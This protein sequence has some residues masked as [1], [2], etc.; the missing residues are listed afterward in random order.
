M[1]PGCS[2]KF[3]GFFGARRHHCR[4]CG[5]LVCDEHS[6]SRLP[7][8]DIYPVQQEGVMQGTVMPSQ[9][10]VL[11]RVCDTCARD[12]AVRKRTM[13]GVCAMCG[14]KRVVPVAKPPAPAPQLQQHP[15]SSAAAAAAAATATAAAAAAAAA[16][17]ASSV[18]AAVTLPASAEAKAADSIDSA[19]TLPLHSQRSSGD[20]ADATELWELMDAMDAM[21]DD[22]TAGDGGG[23]DLDYSGGGSGG[24]EGEFSGGGR[25]MASSSFMVASPSGE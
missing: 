15:Q 13:G 2:E 3:G 21:D 7:L 1:V 14:A 24:G 18:A 10:Q 5:H 9:Q 11:Y 22:E 4:C 12:R 19:P 20:V 16:S 17:T 6:R 8:P 25:T 23:G